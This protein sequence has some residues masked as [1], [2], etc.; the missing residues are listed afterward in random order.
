MQAAIIEQSFGDLYKKRAQEMEKQALVVRQ[1]KKKLII[2]NTH[3]LVPVRRTFVA[4][5]ATRPVD[6]AFLLVAHV[7]LFVGAH[8]VVVSSLVYR[9]RSRRHRR[10][11]TSGSSSVQC[12]TWRRSSA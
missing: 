9:P 7:W 3:E 5:M 6:V 11:G 1:G 2:G 4:V 10:I 8:L 12:W